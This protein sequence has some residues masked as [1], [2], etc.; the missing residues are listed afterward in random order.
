MQE[1]ITSILNFF[2]SNTGIWIYF[3]IPFVSAI[4]GW[5]TN[6]L[7]LKMTFYPTNFIGIPPALGWQGII[8][9]KAGIMAGKAVDLLTKKLIN[10]R[11]IFD[12]LEPEA[13]SLHLQ[14]EL[15]RVSKVI[16]NETMNAQIPRL[17]K[18]LPPLV[19]QRIY[20]E[21]LEQFSP[22]IE[23]VM[24]EI[25]KD[26]DELFDLKAMVI[27][28]L[29]EDKKLLNNIFLKV[30][31]KEFKFIERSG[32]FFGFFFGLIQM[33][34]CYFYN[35]WWM[36]PLAGL[37]VGYATNWLA[38]KLIFEPVNPIKVGPWKIQGLFMKRQVQVAAEYAKIVTANI[39][40]VDNI[41]YKLIEGPKSHKLKSIIREHIHETVDNTIGQSRDFVELVAGPK[42]FNATKNMISW[43]ALQELPMIIR[44][45]YDYAEHT[46]AIEK[47]MRGKMAALPPNDFQGFLRPV[48]QE[49]EW[50]LI[51]VGAIL[52][53]LAGFIQLI[54][55]F[56]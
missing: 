19:K 51:L 14:P 45:V 1:T 42:R 17:W 41:L 37:I 53:C 31:D 43:N 39:L 20:E 22:M 55:V 23:E 29:V 3:T 34:I 9:A 46:L 5:F 27:E 4:V 50:K 54:F 38:L 33:S 28:A 44:H 10:I 24:Q 35:P 2:E 30:G 25:K 47:T 13:V 36:L 26:I 16:I 18:N 21:S 49:D 15:E 52:G 8:P 32:F 56:S 6:V 40:S 12:R 11:E 7:A 48:F